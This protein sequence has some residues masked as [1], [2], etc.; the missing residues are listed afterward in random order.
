MSAHSHNGHRHNGNGHRHARNQRRV[1]A[2]ALLTGGF[3]LAEV[4][5]GLLS[6]SLALLADAGHMLTD[7]GSLA[8]AWFAFR[9]SQR[10][11]DWRRTY[12]FDRFQVLAAYSNGL[13]LFFVAL[14]IV[15]EAVHR[16]QSPSP[17]LAGPMLAIAVAGLVINVAAYFV[18]H[19]AERDNVN[20]K[21]AM[22]HVIGDLLGSTAA[23]AAALI[24]LWTG[25]TPI[26]PLLSILVAGLIL[27]SAWFLIRQ[28]GLILLEAAPEHLDAREIRQSLIA[29]IPGLEDVHHVHVWSLI[30][31]RPMITLHARIMAGA[32]PDWMNA[33]IKAHL[34]ERFAI[35]HA[36]VEIE[37][38]DCGHPFAATTR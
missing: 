2:A 21:G 32:H 5:G 34:K 10:P 28:S 17:I 3:M 24:I 25:W 29:A 15:W 19:G 8:L 4:V 13:T 11:P 37:V 9:V 36:T 30:Q 31:S 6:G 16:L 27:R 7:A 38:Q 33:Q 12:G 26:D 22:L 1:G 20:V 35:D 23:I 18:L 14:V